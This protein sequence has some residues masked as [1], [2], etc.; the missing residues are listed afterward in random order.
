MTSGPDGGEVASVSDWTPPDDALGTRAASGIVWLTAA[1]WVVRVSGLLTLALLTR[2]VGAEAIGTLAAALAIIPM[3]Y[4]LADLGFTTYLLQSDEVDQEQLSTA[5]WASAAAGAVLSVGLVAVAPLLATAF[6]SAELVRALPALVLAVVATVLAA[7]PL[8][9]LKRAMA[10]RVVA[11][12]SL[13]ASLLAQVTAIAIALMGGGVWALIAQVIVTQAVIA[14]LAWRYA[15]WVPSWLLSRRLFW[16][17]ATFGVRVSAVDLVATVRIFAEAW[18]IAA[19]LGPIYL[20]VLLIAQRVVQTAQDLTA[21]SLV[22]V[23]TVLFAKVRE[24]VARLRTTYVKALGASYAVVS[25][26]M[27][28]IIVTAPLIMPLAFGDDGTHG[29]LPVQALAVAG[30]LVLGAMLDH[31][32]FYGIGRP[33]TWL[34]YAVVV[35]A[36]TVATTAFAVHWKLPGVAIGFV[37]VA[38][39]ATVARWL[40]VS[41]VLGMPTT[42]VARPF[43][44][45]LV[46]TALTTV[47]GLLLLHVL[48]PLGWPVLVAAVLTVVTLLLYVTL[49]RLLAVGILENVV[50]VAPVPERYAGTVR[51]VLRLDHAVVR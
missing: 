12:Q 30:I 18:I 49:V 19:A 45:I 25:P 8:A 38:F 28:L 42:T 15:G 17:M 3:I 4:L 29:V 31:G 1:K 9:L 23:A 32:V 46:P 10:F 6:H 22:P 43:G 14:V 27:V 11:V 47:A 37:V 33:G 34:S 16:Q 36:A 7:V 35:D 41:R 2:L 50:R 44:T 40:L 39:L 21:A 24:T 26:L 20:G 13:V 5:F 48:E 51:R